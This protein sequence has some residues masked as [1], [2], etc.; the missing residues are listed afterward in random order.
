[1]YNRIERNIKD[2][3]QLGLGHLLKYMGVEVRIK[4]LKQDVYTDVY[5]SGAGGSHTD[6]D[7]TITVLITGD[8]FSVED[9]YSAGNLTEGFLY[10]HC[11]DTRR[12]SSGDIIEV[13]RDDEVAFRYKIESENSVGMTTKVFKRFNITSLGD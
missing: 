9:S 6:D 3:G 12:V 11:R 4:K 10:I 8:E 13:V 5:G 2:L 7:S 1:M